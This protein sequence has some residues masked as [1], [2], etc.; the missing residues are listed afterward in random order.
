MK[1]ASGI[2]IYLLFLLYVTSMRFETV[3]ETPGGQYVLMNRLDILLFVNSLDIF[4][5]SISFVEI[6]TF[7]RING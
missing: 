1:W 3:C 6:V 2:N 5:E 7:M 4:T